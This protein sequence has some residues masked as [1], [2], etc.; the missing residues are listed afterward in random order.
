MH[1]IKVYKGINERMKIMKKLLKKMFTNFVMSEKSQTTPL[2]RHFVSPYP[3][4]G[5]KEI[6]CAKHTDKNLSTCRLNVLEIDKTPTLSRICKFAYSS[7]TNSTLSQRERVKYGF[8]L[9]EVFSPCRKVKLN[10]GFTLAE[11]LI[12][13]GIIG[14]VAAVTLPTLVSNY[15][16]HVVETSLK[17]SVSVLQQAI[18]L[19]EVDY[20][21]I[22]SWDAV[23]SPETIRKYLMPY[24]PGSKFIYESE[25]KDYYICN[26]KNCYTANGN[27]A[28]GLQLK[29][30][31]ILRVGLGFN[32]PQ[33][34][35][36]LSGRIDLFTKSRKDKTY[37]VGK[38]FFE[39]Y[40][41]KKGQV[42]SSFYIGRCNDNEKLSWGKTHCSKSYGQEPMCTF[43]LECN[44][45]V[46]P[47]DYP[48]KF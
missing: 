42:G 29:T 19:A 39:F 12:T 30:G 17:R 31:E 37:S 11:V 9:A 46:I 28:S 14:I 1:V 40:V 10:F 47:D 36:G 3:T 34:P 24:I 20:G 8:T 13:L 16:K 32:W 15:R 5:E 38:D 18:K 25:L 48:V 6:L 44:N 43:L 27:W 41:S 35:E 45:W 7:L 26:G 23:G 33:H 4:I 21:E 2:I 22:A